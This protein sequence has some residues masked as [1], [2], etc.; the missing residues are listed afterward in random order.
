MERAWR[1]HGESMERAWREH[2]ES[3]ERAWREH[4]ESMELPAAAA[5]Q[6]YALSLLLA[7]PPPLR[8]SCTNPHSFARIDIYRLSP[9]TS[10]P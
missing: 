2:A 9:L 6:A 3:M 5:Q 7:L 10:P 4:G 1:E 8:H